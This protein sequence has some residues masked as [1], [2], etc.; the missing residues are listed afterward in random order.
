MSSADRPGNAAEPERPDVRVLI[1]DDQKVVRD[2]LAMLIGL[3][4]GIDVVGVAIDGDDAVR[5]VRR[6]DPDVV[7]MDLHMPNRNGVEATDELTTS[8]ARARVVVLTTYS[9]DDWVFAALRAGAR[10]FLTKDAGAE[11]IRHAITTVAAGQ[12]QLDPS[13]QRRLLEALPAGDL[14]VPARAGQSLNPAPPPRADR[15]TTSP[16]GDGHGR[17]AFPP[18]RRSG[19]ARPLL[20]CCPCRKT[21]T[22]RHRTAWSAEHVTVPVD[23]ER[24]IVGV[25]PW[26]EPGDQGDDRRS[27]AATSCAGWRRGLVLPAGPAHHRRGHPTGTR[28]RTHRGGP[29]VRRSSPDAGPPG[30]HRPDRQPRPAPDMRSCGSRSSAVGSPSPTPPP[31]GPPG[32]SVNSRWRSRSPV[33]RPGRRH[34]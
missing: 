30:Q 5:Q 25:R 20:V 26:D 4:S 12:A 28:R 18:A 19:D 29:R 9:D 3:L 31:D 2:G 1:A 14:R 10:G 15:V 33:P 13:V 21:G 7:L 27:P 32:R 34:S 16:P 22:D 6:L 24:R 23:P 17:P 11:E 8:G